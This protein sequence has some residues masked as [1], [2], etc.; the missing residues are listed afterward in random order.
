MSSIALIWILTRINIIIS[1]LSSGPS[2]YMRNLFL[3]SKL[4]N[5]RF[6]LGVA[7]VNRVVL[8]LAT[9]DHGKEGSLVETKIFAEAFSDLFELHEKLDLFLLLCDHRH[10]RLSFH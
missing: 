5:H 9:K 6:A 8:P 1:D 3:V 2:V 7:V 4:S 10:R